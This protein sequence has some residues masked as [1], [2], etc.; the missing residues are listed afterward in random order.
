M[1]RSSLEKEKMEDLNL[2]EYLQQG[3]TSFIKA[4]D[5]SG[6]TAKAVIVAVRSANLVNSGPTVILDIE[7]KK[8]RWS[9][10]LNVTNLK[11]MMEL[12]GPVTSKWIGETITLYKV[13]TNNPKTKQE[14]ESLRIK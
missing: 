11:K 4:K 2:N 14:V 7:I 1:I 8:Q 5:I 3:G 12:K 10:P 6:K 13:L 9:L